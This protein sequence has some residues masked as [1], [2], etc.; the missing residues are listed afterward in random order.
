DVARSLENQAGLMIARSDFAA[1]R[2]LLDHALAI[3][4]RKLGP[5][6]PLV[7][8]TLADRGR[9]FAAMGDA[10]R[11]GTCFSPAL[12]I[13]RIDPRTS[14]PDHAST[15]S[16]L[17]RLRWTAGDLTGTIDLALESETIARDWFLRTARGMEEPEALGYEATRSSGL[18]LAFTAAAGAGGAPTHAAV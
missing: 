16:D 1:A 14:G 17:A 3:R 12:A 8:H 11:A 2:A 9:V 13:Q 15:L 18:D 4:E 5:R 6:H 10:A 7:A